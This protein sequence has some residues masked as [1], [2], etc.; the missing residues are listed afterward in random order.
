[1]KN[2]LNELFTWVF[3]I[4]SLIGLIIGIVPIAFLYFN[5][6]SPELEALKIPFISMALSVSILSLSLVITNLYYG[7]K[8]NRLV[9]IPVEH[10]KIEEKLNSFIKINTAQSKLI[11]NVL[12]HLRY[13]IYSFRELNYMVTKK[14]L[15]V[16]E[17]IATNT[18]N[19]LTQFLITLAD[20]IK[21]YCDK[22]TQDDCSITIKLI[23]KIDNDILIKT[24]IRDSSSYRERKESD[25]IDA[26]HPKIYYATDNTAF[27][28]ICSPDFKDTKFISNNLKS[29]FDEGKYTNSNPKW[30]NYYNACA[31]IPISLVPNKEKPH[32]RVILGF[33]CID[34]FKGK[35]DDKFFIDSISGISDIL[36]ILFFELDETV[37]HCQKSGVKHEQISKY[38]NWSQSR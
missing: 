18:F 26:K 14:K 12:H 6:T 11:H 38:V 30:N 16:D 19:S 24:F 34:N 17:I 36:F 23:K 22:V 25:F 8:V 28:T 10:Y 9:T 27:N 15:K 32:E 3:G 31:V 1:M 21:I 13:I 37:L 5:G 7:F 33:L 20:N 2:F 29:L 35:L 4:S